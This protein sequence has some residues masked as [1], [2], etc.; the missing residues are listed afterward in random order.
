MPLPTLLLVAAA[1]APVGVDLSGRRARNALGVD[2]PALGW[3]CRRRL[4]VTAFL[5]AHPR[6]AVGSP[7]EYAVQIGDALG[8]E[9][10]GPR[11]W[12][13]LLTW[14]DGVKAIGGFL[15]VKLL[16]DGIAARARDGNATFG[17][18]PTLTLPVG[19]LLLTV[20]ITDFVMGVRNASDKEVTD[21]RTGTDMAPSRPWLVPALIALLI[22]AIAVP[23]ITMALLQP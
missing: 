20:L 22:A 7:T 9:P 14:R 13:R 17:W 2:D 21:P 12:L 10:G 4:A 8:A 11:S 6:L 16:S 18:P 23:S 19:A 5:A 15:S 1:V 3:V